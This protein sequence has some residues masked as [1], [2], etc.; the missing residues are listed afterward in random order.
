[1]KWTVHPA[2]Q[3]RMKTILSLTFIFS[4]IIFVLL[5]YGIF[6][7]ILGFVILFFSLHSYYFPTHYEVGEDEVTIKNIFTTQRRKLR[8]FKRVYQGKNGVLLSPFSRK[9][10]LNQ[11]RG[12]FLLLPAERDEIVSYLNHIIYSSQEESKGKSKENGAQ[13]TVE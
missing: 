12:V 9:T 6:W 13:K 10:F 2:K 5:F 4:F 11:F 3:N 7:F 1:M 8:E